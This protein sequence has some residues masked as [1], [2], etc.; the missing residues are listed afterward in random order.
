MAGSQ[1]QTQTRTRANIK[2]PDRWNVMF[3][4]DDFT[5]MDFVVQLLVEIFDKS[6]DEARAVTM[7]I[8]EQGKA[9]A[10][11]YFYEVAEQKASEA[12]TVSK[13]H[14]HPLKINLE[15]A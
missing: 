7:A 8:H 6:L 12:S 5:P 13:L 1:T 10:G 3:H 15:I 11:T 4:N 14:G 9:A 2:Y